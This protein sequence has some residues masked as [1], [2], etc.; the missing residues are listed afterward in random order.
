MPHARGPRAAARR[1]PKR[2]SRR[3]SPARSTRWSIPGAARRC[4]SPRPRRRCARARSG[5]ATSATGRSDISTP[6]TVI[7]L[8]LDLDGRITLVNRYACAVL[9]WTEPE[10][11]G[12][13]WFE[14]CLAPRM[15]EQVK[16]RFGD[17]HAATSPIAENV[18]LTRAGEERIIEWRNTLQRDDGGKVIGTLQFW[19]GHDRPEPRRRG[20]ADGRRADAVCARGRQRR[21]LGDGL[22]H[23]DRRVVRDSRGAVRPG[24]R[25]R[26]AE[27]SRRSCACI[28]PE[29]RASVLETIDRSMKSGADF[30]VLHRSLWPDGTVRWLSG[31]GPHP[32]RRA[33]ANRCARVGISMDVTERHTLEEQYRQAQKMEAIGRLA[34][35][36][37]HDFNNLLTVILGF[38]EFVSADAAPR[39]PARAGSRRDHQGGAERLGPHPAAARVQ[40]STGAA[41]GAARCERADRGHDRHARPVDRRAHRDHVDAR[42][43]ISA[44][45]WPIAASWSRWS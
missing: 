4:C 5:C 30:S 44:W 33:S 24:A 15:R 23:R 25:A 1:R 40:P 43:P 21:D 17:L 2:R 27:P 41:R 35:G 32:A 34:S 38:T 7:L 20:R 37:A 16:A 6:P 3:C 29:D 36:V 14:T 28:H 42:R 12:R 31:V 8:A 13:D 11:L 10:L 19:H 39:E 45:R 26:S 18:V 9:G 22:R